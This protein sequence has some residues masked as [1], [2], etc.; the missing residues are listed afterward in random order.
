MDIIICIGRISRCVERKLIGR[1]RIRRSRIQVSR[2]I[3]VRIEKKFWR[4]RQRISK[5]SRTQKDRIGRKDNRGIC[6][7]VSRVARDSRYERRV[8]VEEFKREI[9]QYRES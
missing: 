8:L 7:R 1:F 4:K 2:R 3:F 6:I 9:N 5:S